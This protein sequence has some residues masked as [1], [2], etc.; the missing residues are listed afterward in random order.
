MPVLKKLSAFSLCILLL[1]IISVSCKK[2]STSN[3]TRKLK[4]YTEAITAVGIGHVVETFNINYD[5]QD[6]ITSVVSTTKPGHRLEYQYINKE[7]FTFEKIE[8][9]KVT[10]HCAYYINTSLS[11]V[12][13]VFQYNN[14]KDTIS[15]K[16][17][18]NN[19]KQIEKQKEYLHS[20]YTGPVLYNTINYL[21]DLNGKLT[22]RSDSYSEVSYR[23]DS[24]HINTAHIEPFY[25]PVQQQLPTHT[26]TQRWGT[27][28]TIEHTYSFDEHKRLISEKAVSS[29]GRVTV[30][31]YTYL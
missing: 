29:D 11:L 1:F 4:T 2:E 19:E 16:Y 31:S 3:A 12:D 26:Y 22:R 6:R 14:R 9:N 15:L 8:D 18:Y 5:G 13:S 17:F 10:L 20:Y 27:L 24:L 7:E 30:K 23:Y 28:I 21:Y 25:F